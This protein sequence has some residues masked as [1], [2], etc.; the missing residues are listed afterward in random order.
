MPADHEAVFAELRKLLRAHAG[1]FT[2]AEDSSKRYCLTATPGPA[3]I[4]AWRGELRHPIMPVAW[5]QRSK[6]YVGY[7]LM[8]LYAQPAFVSSMSP[9]LRARLHGK[10]CFN[11]SRTDQIV[12]S[13]LDA[14]T[15]ATIAGLR[16]GG[17]IER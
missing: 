16:R 10:T 8:G 6:S 11:F 4:K 3:T 7:H 12:R 15:A 17:F 14:L 1:Q 9:A 2:V 5:V 13:E